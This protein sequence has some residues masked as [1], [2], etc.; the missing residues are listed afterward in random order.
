[1]NATLHKMTGWT[2]QFWAE[3]KKFAIR[4]NVVDLTIGII[5]GT[6]FT[7]LTNSFVKD[8]VMPPLGFFLD[9]VDFANLF[10]D[11]SGN[12]YATLAQAQAAG[13][14]TINYGLFINALIDFIVLA[15]VIFMVVKQI[16]RFKR[17]DEAATEKKCPFC[18]SPIA[19]AAT[20][21]PH[22]TSTLV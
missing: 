11:L 18:M 22:C 5:V 4:G 15:L 2:G 6:A 10:V 7:A 16:N 8:I 19:T 13:V 21:C 14:P 12:S 9:N 3:F 20:R 17:Q 1:M